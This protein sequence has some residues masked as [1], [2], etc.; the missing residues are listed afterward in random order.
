MS[1]LLG[2]EKGS[3]DHAEPSVLTNDSKAAY[4]A[5]LARTSP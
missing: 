4:F 2:I 3:P 1:L 5:I